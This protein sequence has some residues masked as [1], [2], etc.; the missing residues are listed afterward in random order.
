MPNKVAL[1]TGGSSGIGLR[2]A[3]ALQ[4]A[5]VRVY[6]AARRTAP[7]S[8]LQ[9]AGITTISLDV[10][11][12]ASVSAAVE[13][14]VDAEG[15]I[16][17]LVNN[18]GY[19]SYG[20]LEDVPLAEAQAQFDVNVFGLARLSQLV[21]PHMRS[22]RCGVIVNVSS[23]GG[24]LATPLGCWYHASKYAVEGLS[25]A[26]RLEAEP[27]GIRVVLVEPGSIQTE[28]G[29]IAADNL[30]AMSGSGPYGAQAKA[31]ADRLRA[32]SRPGASLTSPPDVI[33]KTITRAGTARR[34]KTRYV[35]GAGAR[36]LIALRQLLPDRAFDAFIR[37]AT[38]MPAPTTA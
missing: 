37:R 13:Q 8:A 22:R 19:G 25:D 34:P 6:A 26:L 32:S 14:I 23:M 30:L 21:L 9:D 3:A 16:D 36:P 33:A 15:R 10:T 28:W 24:R 12:E 17:I 35:V 4:Q 7:M 29:A 1:V 18:A 31:V 2:T 5:G 27:W 11:D 20:A 38:R